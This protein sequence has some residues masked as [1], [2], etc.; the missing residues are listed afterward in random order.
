MGTIYQRRKKLADG[1]RVPVGPFWIAYYRNGKQH[2]E[3]TGST[4]RKDAEHTLKLR[5]GD[6]ERGVPVTAKVNQLRFEKARD[7]F[8]AYQ[9]NNLRTGH[10]AVDARRARQHQKTK[11]RIELRLTPFFGGRRM[12][13]ITPVDIERYKAARRAE[14]ASPAT[15]NREL[16]ILK[17]MFSL[18]VKAG[19]LYL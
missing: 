1:T 12:V 8:L 15:I 4:K 5:E 6:I 14:K 18:A 13:S 16:T 19:L 17:R 3:S 9:E 11:R 10:A 7:H 2:H